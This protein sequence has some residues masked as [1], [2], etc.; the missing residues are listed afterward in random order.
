MTLDA[1]D[2][3]ILTVLGKNGRMSNRE[4]ARAVGI[5]EGTVRERLKKLEAGKAMRL[6]V[7]MDVT[8]AGLTTMAY[9]RIKAK[10]DRIRAIA[11]EIAAMS[12]CRFAG[13]SL[14]NFDIIALFV[15]ASRTALAGLIDNRIAKIA[16]V[17]AIDVRE[18]IASVKHRYDLIHIT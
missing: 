17:I 9:V 3:A 18:P 7:V 15:A 4:V 11:E 14:G 6:G 8:A 1:T 16:G 2:H 12:D 5:S 10:P 13:L